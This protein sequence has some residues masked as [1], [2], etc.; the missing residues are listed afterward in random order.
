[1]RL[2]L[3]VVRVHAVALPRHAHGEDKHV[4]TWRALLNEAAQTVDWLAT[5]RIAAT[6]QLTGQL[7]GQLTSNTA[8]DIWA[9]QACT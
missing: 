4:F 1:M 6:D 5:L 9:L 3:Q 8:V 7:T 2:M